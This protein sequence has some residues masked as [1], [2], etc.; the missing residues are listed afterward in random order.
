MPTLEELLRTSLKGTNEKFDQ[1]NRALHAAVVEAAKAVE[2]VTNGKATL[3]L[4]EVRNDDAQTR[5][6]LG[7]VSKGTGEARTVTY[8]AVTRRGFPISR[9]H[10]SDTSY[11]QESFD[12]PEKLSLY[13]QKLA[14][15]P[16][17]PLVAYLAYFVR[18]FVEGAIPF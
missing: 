18:N 7:V 10:D 3:Q 11:P 8:L 17:S 6:A 5:Y 2:A 12:T 13:L 14:S 9:H 1:A 15:D 16:D 4:D